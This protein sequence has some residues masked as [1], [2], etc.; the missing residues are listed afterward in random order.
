MA[1]IATDVRSIA[2]CYSTA[3]NVYFNV[4]IFCRRSIGLIPSDRRS[5]A[6]RGSLVEIG[7]ARTRICGH[8]RRGGAHDRDREDQ[9]GGLRSDRDPAHGSLLFRLGM[10][11]RGCSPNTTSR[12]PRR[13]VCRMRRTSPALDPAAAAAGERMLTECLDIVAT[14]GGTPLCGV[15]YS[16]MKKYLQPATS[17]GRAA[18]AGALRRL[19]RAPTGWASASRSRS[20]TATRRTSSTRGARPS[21]SSTRSITRTCPC[22]STRYH[23]NIE[24]SGSVRRRCSTRERR[25]G[26][27]HIG[28]SHRGYL[29]SGHRRLRCALPRPRPCRLR[30]SRGVRI[31]LVGRGERRPQ[32]HAGDLAQPVGGLR[33]PRG[34]R[35]QLHPRP[36][37]TVGGVDRDALSR[38]C[39][40]LRRRAGVRLR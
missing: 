21:P 11:P 28:E 5:P 32:Q 9:D 40:G 39:A 2:S 18:S 15:I 1:W 16:A 25:L 37:S 38:G 29:G 22:T 3:I 10:L 34:A 36:A 19:A 8:V 20:S 6:N 35:E 13:S 24:E 31:L 30:R 27:V 14:M 7:A 33:R 4:S 23:M 12:Q 26:Y 17:E